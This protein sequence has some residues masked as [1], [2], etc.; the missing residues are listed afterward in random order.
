MRNL[1]IDVNFDEKFQSYGGFVKELM[2]IYMLKCMKSEID[3]S[4]IDLNTIC[5][6]VVPVCN[7]SVSLELSL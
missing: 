5:E 3:K 7:A 4:G 2:S 1:L 6:Y